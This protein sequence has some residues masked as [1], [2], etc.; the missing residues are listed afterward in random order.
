MTG[1]TASSDSWVRRLAT[2]IFVL[3]LGFHAWGVSV[4]WKNINLPGHEFRQ[5]QTGI[6]AMFIQREGNFSL[7]YPTPVLGKPWSVPFEFPLYQWTVAVVSN[8]FHLP[9]VQ[10]ARAVSVACFYGFL[11]ALALWLRRLGLSGTQR[12]VTL[13]LVLTCPLY[14]FYSRAFLIETMALMFGVWYLA[15]LHESVARR[16][17]AW[18]AV[19]A[20]AGTG[21]GLVKVTTFIVCLVPAFGWCVWW[22]WQC[23]PAVGAADRWSLARMFGWLAA[24]HAVPFAATIGWVKYADAVKALNPSGV[25]LTSAGLAAFNFG[26]GRHF[27]PKIWAAWHGNITETICSLGV[28]G[29]AFGLACFAGRWRWH[30]FAALGLFVVSQLIFPVLYAF[31]SYYYVAS[32]FTLFVGLGFAL[33]GLLDKRLPR[34]VPLAAWLIVLA[35]QVRFFLTHQY[36]EQRIPGNGGGLAS[37]LQEFTDQERSLIIAGNDWSSIIPYYAERRALMIRSDLTH[38]PEYLEKAFAKM[39]DAQVAALVLMGPERENTALLDLALARFDLD[40]RPILTWAHGDQTATVYLDRQL[41]PNARTILNRRGFHEA[42]AVPATGPEPSPFVGK[43]YLYAQLL[44]EFKKYFRVMTPRPIRFFSTF[45]P[46]LWNDDQPGQERYAAHSDTKLWFALTPGAHR[47]QTD[48]EILDASWQGVP[49]PDASDGV[50]VTADAVFPD[51]RRER[52][53]SRY[54]FP[55]VRP[56]DRGRQP[57]DWAFELPAGAELEFG[58]NAGP[59]GNGARDWATL[60]YITIK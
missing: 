2:V 46:E 21:A 3:A 18:L 23:R 32:A 10:A 41:R 31:H 26:Y 45:G 56:E 14:I 6:S 28:L 51:G 60:G 8:T 16:S 58:V 44:P 33:S 49:I 12:A 24:G 1:H 22:L 7:A 48:I 36:D 50:E 19:A 4:G 38:R 59:A 55:R 54:L 34:W 52:L 40:P 27:D 15:A 29:A 9:L 43:P 17:G 5:A 53:H 13:S 37:A 20:L 47:I 35:T 30:A 11:V 25:S 57:I 42:T 39:Q